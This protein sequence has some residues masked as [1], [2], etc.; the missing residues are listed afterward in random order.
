MDINP[1][2]SERCSFNMKRG[3]RNANEE[4]KNT[5]RE[6]IPDHN[7]PDQAS[8]VTN[9]FGPNYS[10]TASSNASNVYQTRQDF[11]LQ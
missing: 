5:Q 6:N 11:D 9:F 10:S 8:F 4:V 3:Q 1:G 7:V 2:T